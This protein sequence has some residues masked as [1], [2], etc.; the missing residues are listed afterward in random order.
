[1]GVPSR[2]SAV[3]HVLFTRAFHSLALSLDEGR[4]VETGRPEGLLPKPDGAYKRFV[5]AQVGVTA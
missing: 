1:M 4:I 2:T 3:A 5:E